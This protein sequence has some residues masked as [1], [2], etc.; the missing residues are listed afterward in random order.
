MCPSGAEVLG[1]APRL[2]IEVLDPRHRYATL[3]YDYWRRWEVSDTRDHF[4]NWIDG[5]SGVGG[6]G[7]LIDLPYAPRR[8]LDEWQV[9][10]LR[11]ED[12]DLFRVSIERETGRFLWALDGTPVTLPAPLQRHST[13]ADCAEG[14]YDPADDHL[15]ADLPVSTTMRE[16][17]VAGLLK[18]L[19]SR[20]CRRDALLERARQLV[21][22]AIALGEAPCPVRVAEIALPLFA[23]G[24][25][26]QLRDPFFKERHDAATTPNG[27]AHLRLMPKLPEELLPGRT[28]EHFLNAIDHDQGRFMKT[29]FAQGRARAHGKGIF[30]WDTFGLLYCGTKLRGNFHHSSFVRGHCVKVAGGIT[31]VDGTLEMLTPHS[32]HYQ[33]GEEHV[34]DM[35]V[36]WRS[37]GVDFSHVELKPYTKELKS[38]KANL[39]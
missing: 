11:R 23:E 7:S 25:L 29:P 1:L 35:I 36:E 16:A 27:H 39:H 18:P 9:I 5:N 13:P 15:P 26:C 38:V 28:W 12:Q 3:L 17:R 31:I 8:L 33:P 32:G 2:W 21:E 30:V 34:N 19:L 24:L 20:S 22:A 10:Y 14:I 37:R 6:Q 4:F